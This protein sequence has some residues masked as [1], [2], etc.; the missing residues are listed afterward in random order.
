MDV[1]GHVQS[2]LYKP[3]RRTGN[4]TSVRARARDGRAELMRTLILNGGCTMSERLISKQGNGSDD[5]GIAMV[6]CK[7]T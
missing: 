6:I 3:D 4:S 5:S 7:R 1:L 2:A